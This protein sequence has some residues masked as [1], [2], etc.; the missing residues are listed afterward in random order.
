MTHAFVVRSV[1]VFHLPR[2]IFKRFMAIPRLKPRSSRWRNIITVVSLLVVAMLSLG[3]LVLNPSEV[4]TVAPDISPTRTIIIV[5]PSSLPKPTQNRGND[6]GAISLEIGSLFDAL[7]SPERPPFETGNPLLPYVYPMHASLPPNRHGMVWNT[8]RKFFADNN[9][10][11]QLG[12]KGVS[13]PTDNQCIAHQGRFP[14]F[15]YQL[16]TTTT[17]EESATSLEKEFGFTFRKGDASSSPPPA[18]FNS[19]FSDSDP[20]QFEGGKVPWIPGSEDVEDSTNLPCTSFIQ[21]R[22]WTLN[23]NTK[24]T[25]S[26]QRFLVSTLKEGAHGVGSAITL[27]AHDLL[28]AVVLGRVLLIVPEGG[29]RS[30]WYFSGDACA[31]S[32][33]PSWS[34]YFTEPSHCHNDIISSGK[35]FSLSSVVKV[36]SKKEALLPQMHKQQFIR[37]KTFDAKGLGRND[38]L[39]DEEFFGAEFM[40]SPPACY[41]KYQEWIRD[42]SNINIQG[43]FSKGSD[44]R[45]FFML[46]QATKYLMRYQ[47][48]WFSHMLS[49]KLAQVGVLQ[50]MQKT[51][52]TPEHLPPT[53]Y[54][55]ERGEIAKFR[56]Y[57]NTFGC[58]NIATSIHIDLIRHRCIGGKATN[59]GCTVFVSGNTPK[60]NY[61]LITNSLTNES[62]SSASISIRS[63]WALLATA[64]KGTER[65]GASGLSASWV[66]MY[67]A[68]TASSWICIV[69]SNW[70]RVINFLRLTTGR[71]G[72]PFVDAGAL[73]IASVS[74][75]Q[76]YCLIKSEWPTKAFSNVVKKNSNFTF[77]PSSP[78]GIATTGDLKSL[79]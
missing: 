16:G 39:T 7:Q 51:P 26:H 57:F 61:N 5:R 21:R 73:M 35:H 12:E 10:D 63:T 25:C 37:K 17:S 76:R 31:A 53:I 67:A 59:I 44:R 71:A 47:Q 24:E 23:H 19:E 60:E 2:N 15:V 30:K 41:A 77:P 29:T 66:D 13:S 36:A 70:C 78:E 45:L 49:L 33:R 46:S 38:V 64:S 72:C 27:I 55:Q 48:P 14:S 43:T 18:L 32:G 62:S 68:L 40:K 65:W 9:V 52:P 50:D 1:F 34:C 8:L 75:R 74:L 69:Q 56:E 11:Q 6:T 42:D 20:A 4:T 3:S 28:S 54:V 58:H 22:L 79:L